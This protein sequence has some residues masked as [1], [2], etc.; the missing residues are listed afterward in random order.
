MTGPEE[1]NR[2]IPRRKRK[3]EKKKTGDPP[4]SPSLFSPTCLPNSSQAGI[5]GEGAKGG[6]EDLRREERE[7]GVAAKKGKKKGGDCGWVEEERKR[8]SLN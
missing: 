5:K 6:K 3:G 4:F 8:K 1:E 7:E 2:G